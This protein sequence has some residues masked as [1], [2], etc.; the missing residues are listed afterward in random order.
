MGYSYNNLGS[1]GTATLVES[2]LS[3]LESDTG[4]SVL[5]IASSLKSDSESIDAKAVSAV[6]G[7]GLG[8]VGLASNPAGWVALGT[9]AIMA[10]TKLATNYL[11]TVS[12]A[13]QKFE[14]VDTLGQIL[15]NTKLYTYP[16]KITKSIGDL[17]RG[18]MIKVY[19]ISGRSN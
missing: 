6:L 8:A 9:M 13:Y 17:A 15:A 16:K 5:Q 11:G 7:S 10:G 12:T 18:Q 14:K 19:S 3:F 2:G 4:Q 1:N